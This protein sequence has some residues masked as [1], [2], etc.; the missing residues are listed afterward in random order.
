[1]S[2]IIALAALTLGVAGVI[3]TRRNQFNLLKPFSHVLLWLIVIAGIAVVVDLAYKDEAI[4]QA[5]RQVQ[6]IEAR[7]QS[8]ALKPFD[9]AK[10]P[11]AAR[12]LIEAEEGGRPLKLANFSG[13]FPSFGRKGRLGRISVVL[14]SV[15]AVHADVSV[16]GDD[17]VRFTETDAEGRALREGEAGAWFRPTDRPPFAHGSELRVQMP[18]ARVLSTLKANAQTPLGT[19]EFDIPNNPRTRTSVALSFERIVATFR[20]YVRQDTGYQPCS[21]IITVPMRFEIEPPQSETRMQLTLR[22]IER[23]MLAVDC[24]DKPP[25]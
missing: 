7:L 25:F 22:L 23:E 10:A 5:E 21:A 18:L 8:L 12:F 19:L 4:R 16:E 15:F 24:S 9:L 17:S 6:L 3:F 13:P 11:A 2:Y 20:F 14:P 1:M